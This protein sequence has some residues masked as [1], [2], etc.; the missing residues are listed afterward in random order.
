MEKGMTLKKLYDEIGKAIKK[1]YGDKVCVVA[2]D[3]E[4]NGFHKMWYSVTDMETFGIHKPEE[5]DIF[6]KHGMSNEE[7]FDCVIIG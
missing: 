1:G 5:L 3:D 6:H 2:D 7:L 4:C